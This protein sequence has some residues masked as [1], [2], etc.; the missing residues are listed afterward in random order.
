MRPAAE[1]GIREAVRAG[2]LAPHQVDYLLPQVSHGGGGVGSGRSAAGSTP[3][4]G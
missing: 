1:D 3:G 4:G 2:L